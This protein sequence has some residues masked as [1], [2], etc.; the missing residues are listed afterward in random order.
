MMSCDSDLHRDGI[1]FD[2]S[3][4][5][6]WSGGPWDVIVVSIAS[7]LVAH[8]ALIEAVGATF[9]RARQPRIVITGT[10]GSMN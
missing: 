9:A 5:N 4:L 3:G 2:A 1:A 6:L 10:S 7:A 8:P